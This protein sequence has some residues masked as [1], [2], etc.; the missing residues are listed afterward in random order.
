MISELDMLGLFVSGFMSAGL[1][2][3]WFRYVRYVGSPQFLKDR[4]RR[5]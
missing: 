3:L 1:L 5:R 4:W 2:M